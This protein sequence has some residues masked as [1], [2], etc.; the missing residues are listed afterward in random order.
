MFTDF[1]FILILLFILFIIFNKIQSSPIAII[2]ITLLYIPTKAYIDYC[3]SLFRKWSVQY[4]HAV[5]SI[6]ILLIII[7]IIELSIAMPVH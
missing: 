5:F 2:L 1:L 4:A 7:I 3:L 6:I